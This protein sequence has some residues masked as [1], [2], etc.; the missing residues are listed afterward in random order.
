MDS[1]TE[2]TTPAALATELHVDAKRVRAWLRKQEFRSKAELGEHWDLSQTQSEAVRQALAPSASPNAP[3]FDPTLLTVGEI[4]HVY[5]ALL[6]ELGRRGLVR[7]NNAPI[8]DLAEY[9]C[10]TYYEGELAS[11]SEKSYDLISVDGRRVQVKVRNVREG[12]RPSAV[13]SSIRSTDFDI[14]VFILANASTHTIDAAYEWTPEEIQAHGRFTS[15]TNSTLIRIGKVR[16]GVAGVDI[17]EGLN[18]A[19]RTMLELES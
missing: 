1:S 5:T 18:T 11:N 19:W 3:G 2:T 16:A 17:T 7:T 12:T 14:C 9:A 10:A 4:L 6:V 13:F 8:G 15:H